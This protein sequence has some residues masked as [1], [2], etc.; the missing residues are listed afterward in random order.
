M[1]TLFEK[2]VPI[3][4][5][6]ENLNHLIFKSRFSNE[7][8]TVYFNGP[9]KIDTITI[10]NYSSLNA[11]ESIASKNFIIYNL[12]LESDLESDLENDLENDLDLENENIDE[13]LE[14][15]KNHIQN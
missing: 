13:K 2:I 14:N 8:D 1:D 6:M 15:I 5:K 7:I 10:D 3:I 4:Y 12:D 11:F 9:L